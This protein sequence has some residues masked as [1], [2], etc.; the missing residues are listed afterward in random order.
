MSGTGEEPVVTLMVVPSGD[1]PTRSLPLGR[2]K[3]RLALALGAVAV[4]AAGALLASWGYLAARAWQAGQLEE[5]VAQ[6]RAEQE[7]M[8]E[9]AAT[10]A[11]VEAGYERLRALFAPGEGEGAGPGELWL[12]P[13]GGASPG[14]GGPVLGEEALPT[15]WPLTQR[16]FVTQGLIE[17][18]GGDHPGID[19]AVP[20]G[21]YIRAAGPGRV[22]EAAEDR[23]YGL[24]VLLDHGGGYRSLYA[25]ASQLMVE[26]GDRVERGEVIGLTGSSG[27]SS[28][29]HLHFEILRD[30]EPL[31]PLTLVQPP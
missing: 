31:D 27:R 4:L 10:L 14:G 8:A 9:L 2:R 18:A 13:P 24:Y 11:E 12:P 30:G 19:V 21:S 5:E 15:T 1:R 26:P 29:P 16:G 7:Q 3:L 22:V 6:L 28:A 23:V 25:H 17:D 20:A